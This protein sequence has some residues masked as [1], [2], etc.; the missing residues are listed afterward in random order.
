MLPRIE[1]SPPSTAMMT[2]SIERRKPAVSGVT[3]PSNSDEV[4][5]GNRRID[6]RQHENEQL[7][8]RDIDAERTRGDF[9]VVNGAEGAA[10]RAVD[11]VE[12]EPCGEH[13]RRCRRSS[14]R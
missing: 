4:G 2:N 9:A 13:E 1:P 6:R 14:T 5:T 12:R 3:K 11:E 10:G 7:V 8:A